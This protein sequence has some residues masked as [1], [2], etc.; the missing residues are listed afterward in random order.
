MSTGDRRRRQTTPD[1]AVAFAVRQ[2]GATVDAFQHLGFTRVV[3][4]PRTGTRKRR[5]PI[6]PRGVSVSGS[7][8][9]PSISTVG[10]PRNR[11]R[12]QSR[13]PR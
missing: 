8:S 12:L 4:D 6:D 9:R 13:R 3:Q 2:S 10:D 7:R 11:E 5:Q 1:L